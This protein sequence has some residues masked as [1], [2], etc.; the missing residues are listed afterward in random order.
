MELNPCTALVTTPV[1][2]VGQREVGAE[3]QRHAIEQQQRS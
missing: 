3:G 2:G 1:E